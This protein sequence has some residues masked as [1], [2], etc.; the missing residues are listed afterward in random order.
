MTLRNCLSSLVLL[1]GTSAL[2]HDGDHAGMTDAAVQL[3]HLGLPVAIAAIAAISLIIIT[4]Y[5]KRAAQ[6]AADDGADR[7]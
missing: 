6:L 1:S 3:H 4:S 7:R 5:R 2:A